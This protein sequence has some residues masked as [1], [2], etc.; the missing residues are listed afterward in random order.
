MNIAKNTETATMFHNVSL[1]PLCVNQI[2]LAMDE[3]MG[4]QA[5]VAW[6]S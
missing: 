5:L 2:V 1:V 4:E 3:I 6:K